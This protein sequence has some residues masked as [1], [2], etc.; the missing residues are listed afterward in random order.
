[1]CIRDSPDTGADLVATGNAESATIQGNASTAGETLNEASKES[2]GGTVITTINTTDAS[3]TNQSTSNT[4]QTP[5]LA[6]DGS[7]STA[8]YLAA[9]G[10]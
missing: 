8:R 2:A 7:D 6:V 10:I 5:G 1:M 4:T 3:Q 9:A